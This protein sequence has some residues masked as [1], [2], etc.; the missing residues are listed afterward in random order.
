M[1]LPYPALVLPLAL[2]AGCAAIYPE[3][4]TRTH[5][6]PP[7]QSV[8]PPPPANLKWVRFV[9]G[10]LPD[11]TRDGRPWQPDGQATPYARLWING[12]EALKTPVEHGTLA[13]TWPDGPK[14]NFRINPED[15]LRIE[16]WNLDPVVDKPVIIRELGVP[17]E[18]RLQDKV[19]RIE[20]DTGARIILAF[21]PAHAL[22]GLGLWY[23]LRE[24]GCAITRILY[25]SPAERAGLKPADDVIKI[26]TKEVKFMS[27]Q[28]V[29]SAFSAVPVHGLALVVKHPDGT[30]LDVVVKEGPIFGH[31]DQV[32]NL[33]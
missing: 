30:V 10:L 6:I 24:R 16:L 33:E 31:F 15:H 21:E 20:E 19:I 17:P 8:D 26:G 13:P 3:L 28:E 27:P 2:L 14:G 1:R 11:H 18:E 9:S 29:Q 22:G 4:E 32:G 7:G 12:K 23:E 5:P 25:D